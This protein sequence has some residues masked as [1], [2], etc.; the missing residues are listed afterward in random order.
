MGQDILTWLNGRLVSDL[1]VRH[2]GKDY[3]IWTLKDAQETGL[4]I[5]DAVYHFV[6]QKKIDLK[7]EVD[8]TKGAFPPRGAFSPKKA[9]RDYKP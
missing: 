2:K 1:I 3:R 7:G 8:G 4:T 6:V 9:V 5:E